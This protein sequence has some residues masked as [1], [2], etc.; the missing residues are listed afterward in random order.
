MFTLPL[1]ARLRLLGARLFGPAVG[2]RSRK[3]FTI[4]IG[5]ERPSL[6]WRIL[7]PDGGYRYQQLTIQEQAEYLSSMRGDKQRIK[8][9]ATAAPQAFIR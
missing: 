1:K 7:R 9:P 4:V 8:S 5:D 2:E 6:A 3:A